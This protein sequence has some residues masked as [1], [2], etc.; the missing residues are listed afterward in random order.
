MKKLALIA[1]LAG[2]LLIGTGCN[3]NNNGQPCIV[4][5]WEGSVNP[6]GTY[7]DILVEYKS[8]GTGSIAIR[9]CNNYCS[10]VGQGTH[11]NINYMTFDYTIDGNEVTQIVQGQIIVCGTGQGANNIETNGTFTCDDNTLVS[12]SAGGGTLTLTRVD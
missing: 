10:Q 7:C 11:T 4:G 2:P 9:D 12:S 1:L 5:K 6:T 8:D 3:D